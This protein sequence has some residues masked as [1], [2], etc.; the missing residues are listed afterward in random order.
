MQALALI[1]YIFICR[2][3]KWDYLWPA[4]MLASGSFGEKLTVIGWAALFMSGFMWGE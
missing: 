3:R 2:I 1:I 4:T